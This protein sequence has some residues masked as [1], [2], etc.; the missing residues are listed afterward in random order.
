MELFNHIFQLAPGNNAE[1]IFPGGPEGL[2]G[3]HTGMR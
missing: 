3:K 1:K 2:P